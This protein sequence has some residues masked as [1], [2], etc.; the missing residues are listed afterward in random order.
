MGAGRRGN[1][2]TGRRLQ[3]EEAG[4]RGNLRTHPRAG[5][6]DEMDRATWKIIISAPETRVSGVFDFGG[7]FFPVERLE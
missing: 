3:H 1:P 5:M 6:G 7:K 4:K 2:K